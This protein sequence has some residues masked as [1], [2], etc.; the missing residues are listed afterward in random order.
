ME[1]SPLGSWIWSTRRSTMTPLKMDWLEI[2]FS[3]MSMS[4]APNMQNQNQYT[5]V[6][7]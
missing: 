1:L 7:L 6:C 4:T 3:Y 2:A 5:T